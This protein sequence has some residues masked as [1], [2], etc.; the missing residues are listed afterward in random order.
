MCS[1]IEVGQD[2]P[3]IEKQLS[4]RPEGKPAERKRLLCINK[5]AYTFI[6]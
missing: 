6:L 5:K 1:A 2:Q 4:I 3:A